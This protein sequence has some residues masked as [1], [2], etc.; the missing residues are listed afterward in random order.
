MKFTK[1]IAAVTA[2]TIVGG[3]PAVCK[4]SPDNCPLISFAEAAEK[5]IEYTEGIY[6][7]TLTVRICDDHIEIIDCDKAAEGELDIPA[8]IDGLPV[9]V[10]GEDAFRGC[11]YLTKVIVPDTVTSIGAAA[12][13]ACTAL[14]EV[15]LP[16][17]ITSIKDSAF[18]FCT[19]LKTVNIPESVTS[20][21]NFAFSRCESLASISLPKEITSIGEYAFNYCS[22]IVS[23]TI[24]A[25][26]ETIEQYTFDACASL[27]EVTI[28][29]PDCHFSSANCISNLSWKISFGGTIYGYEGS[30]AQTFAKTCGYA[31]VALD[32]A[33][34]DHI[35]YGD[36]N[37]DKEV[38]IGDA[39]LIMQAQSNPNRYGLYGSDKGHITEQGII[40]GDVIG[41]D[42]ITNNDAL[43]IQKYLLKLIPSL[44][45][46]E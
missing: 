39:V 28:L 6:R 20:I 18:E 40:N 36:A 1:I 4:G 44:P 29:N 19:K 17:G 24:P 35:L 22:S 45:E 34:D 12:F 14:T 38:N 7:E 9:T 16:N 21:G 43:S 11:K 30:T 13:A 15:S 5:D 37:C 41:N 26:V 31:F 8:E 2:L 42:G 33:P 27:N 23:V 46:L 25:K 32:E 3:V 10:I